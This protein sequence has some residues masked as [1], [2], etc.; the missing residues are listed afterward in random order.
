MQSMAFKLLPIL[1]V[2]FL[3]SGFGE[4][5]AGQIVSD[6][7][8]NTRNERFFEDSPQVKFRPGLSVSG[9]SSAGDTGYGLKEIINLAYSNSDSEIRNTFKQILSKAKEPLQNN[10]EIDH[11]IKN[12]NILQYLAFEALVSLI[13]EKNGL[14]ADESEKEYG[15]SIRTHQ[16]S[17]SIFKHGVIELARNNKFINKPP[18]GS[19]IG[20]YVKIVRSYYMIARALDLYLGIENAYSYFNLD[21]SENSLLLSENE[22]REVMQRFISDI[23][24][25]YNNGLKKEYDLVFTIL[26]ED[27]FEPGNRPLKGYLALGYSALSVQTDDQTIH[28]RMMSYFQESVYRATP[29][30]ADN[31]R[32]RYWMYQT[33]N[34]SRFWAEGPYYMDFVL[35]DAL[36]FWHA[37]RMND[38]LKEV[39]DPF[40][41]PWFINP[42]NWLADIST[43]DGS[44]PP[45]NDGNKRV[46]QSVNMLR[47]SPEYGDASIGSKYNTVHR[48]ILEHHQTSEFDDQYLLV[49]LAIPKYQG[50]TNE[51]E[52]LIDPE[53]QQLLIRYGD[54]YD[55][56]HYVLLN[57][58]KGNSILRGEGHQ[59]PDQLQLLYY[60]NEHSFLLDPGYDSGSPDKNSFRSGYRY[61]NTMQYN[62]ATKKTTLGFVTEQNEGGLESPFVSLSKMRKVSTHNEAVFNVQVKGD[63]LDW[64]TGDVDLE[65]EDSKAHYRRILLTVKGERPYLVDINRVDALNGR[66]DFVMRYYGNSSEYSRVNDWFVWKHS[67]SPFASDKDELYLYNKP[68]IGTYSEKTELIDILEYENRVWPKN[69][70]Q[71][72]PVIRKSYYSDQSSDT[73][74][75]ISL[76]KIE[77]NKIVDDNPTQL[78]KQENGL[79][80]LLHNHNDTT[81]DL[82]VYDQRDDKDG[83]LLTMIPE[84]FESLLFGFEPKSEIGFQRL[85]FKEGLW[86]TDNNY[87]LNIIELGPP[88]IKPLSIEE[89]RV[90]VEWELVETELLTGYVLYRGT[91]AANIE[92]YKRLDSDQ[93]KYEEQITQDG[94][95]IYALRAIY[96]DNTLSGLSEYVS[97]Y[98][99]T[100]VVNDVWSLQS[101]AISD[102]EYDFSKIQLFGFNGVYRRNNSMKPGTGYW[103]RSDQ[104]VVL[105]VKGQG[106]LHTEVDLDA[107]WNLIGSLSLALPVSSIT[108]KDGILSQA[109]LWGFKD[110]V[111]KQ[112]EVLYPGSGY[113]LHAK[114]NGR[115]LL[116]AELSESSPSKDLTDHAVTELHRLEIRS[117][118][119]RK[120]LWISDLP[121]EKANKIKFLAPPESPELMLDV[122][123]T[124]G[125]VIWEPST[126][127]VH[128]NTSLY[129]LE[130]TLKT[131]SSWDENYI[132]QLTGTDTNG[133]FQLLLRQEQ[134]V[135]I[136][137]NFGLLQLERINND[138]TIQEYFVFPNYPNPFNLSTSIRYQLPEQNHVLIEVFNIAGQRVSTLVNQEQLAGMYTIQFDGSSHASGVY[139]M[140]FQ[141]GSFSQI[142]KITLIK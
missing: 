122:R 109:P 111:Y 112:T 16:E 100:T 134:P 115:V 91:S 15:I 14:S 99:G 82:I 136:D 90:T 130:L 57:G 33:D 128:I 142:Q 83:G 94:S 121:M 30:S 17:M 61:N 1:L 69:E 81:V 116:N 133:D 24:I 20:D 80:F 39:N 10:P 96:G 37:V 32:D 140:R 26:T 101:V 138:E 105:P 12:N 123:T 87:Q 93:T 74:A 59:Q 60:M 29:G 78:Y 79:Q 28:N 48:S 58:E 132:Y 38:Q 8:Y 85:V 55:N 7:P 98:R 9:F 3:L 50:G 95:Y 22:K 135:L 36:M 104:E 119:R 56:R 43:P 108:D 103:I 21:E 63:Y 84:E 53:E 120:H 5:A 137:R 44:V 117:G 92:E 126:M 118:N 18:D 129:P 64:I 25:L 77:S 31:I 97:F 72:Y 71:T 113:W 68:L 86:Q 106:L 110:G 42:V 107:G 141:A 40:R 49:E 52:S 41:S 65:F 62:A 139:Y 75:T 70:K 125:Y 27:Q 127:G 89:D 46:I 131:D 11:V 76:L 124:D 47:W 13:L 51:L 2:Y 6:V 73:F 66:N 88:D 45:L 23:D 102:F 4:S 34:G 19:D 114:E 35:K 54:E 67:A